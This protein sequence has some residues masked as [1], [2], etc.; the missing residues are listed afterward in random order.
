MIE[1]YYEH[2]D[3]TLFTDKLSNGLTV[4]YLPK[5]GRSKTYGIFRTNFGSLDISFDGK[6]YPAGIAHFLEHKLFEKEEGDVMLKFGALGAQTNAFTSF[7]RT[8]YL[9]MGSENIPENVELLLNFVQEP[10]F[11]EAS[12]HK[13]QGIITQEIQ[14]YQDDPDWKLYAGLLAS[15]Y[16]NSPLAQ[17]IAGTPESIAEITPEMLYEN[18]R[19][20]YQPSNMSLFL[21]G[22]FDV[23]E[24]SALVREN[25][26]GKEFSAV[27]IERAPL[28]FEPAVPFSEISMEVSDTKLGLGL[29]GNNAV[30]DE[31]ALEYRISM[32]I[33]FAM[34]FGRT[35]EFFEEAYKSGLLDDSFNYE[36]EYSPQFQCL[37]ITLD[38]KN[39]E[40][41]SKILQEQLKKYKMRSDTNLAHF[42]LLRR[43]MLGNYIESLN[44]LEHIANEFVA[45]PAD[46]SK[47]LFDVL[48]VLSTITFEKTLKFAE[49]FLKDA[50]TSIFIIRPKN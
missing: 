19:T 28:A 20:F 11:T 43:Q 32:L 14:M 10:Y 40:K 7:S 9:F 49:K 12:V 50:E 23:N 22:P 31:E 6:T 17:D 48:D 5:P 25:Q 15:L 41:L 45:M 35:G 36:F 34:I 4:Y 1:K 26:A 2:I 47:T 39:P 30:E 38:T 24:I 13:E 16:P 42:E 21:T 8:A 3:E 46:S 44:S 29:R 33:F 27:K 18:Y 37:L